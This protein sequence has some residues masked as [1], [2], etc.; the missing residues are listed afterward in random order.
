MH[1]CTA[2]FIAYG[3][4]RRNTRLLAAYF[5]RTKIHG[6]IFG[7][8]KSVAGDARVPLLPNPEYM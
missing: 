2:F 4:K 6:W 7:V 1:G 5:V 8:K 3:I